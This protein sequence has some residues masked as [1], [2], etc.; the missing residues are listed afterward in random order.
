FDFAFSILEPGIKSG[1]ETWGIE[2]SKRIFLLVFPVTHSLF[3][4]EVLTTQQY[5]LIWL[6]TR[7]SE[8]S[9]LS[10]HTHRQRPS[11][12]LHQWPTS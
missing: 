7:T 12:V 6:E 5:M 11:V 10:F 3:L 8:D 1:T 9:L 4:T 2:D